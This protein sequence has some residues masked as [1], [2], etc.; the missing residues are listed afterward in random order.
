MYL[1]CLLIR[2]NAEFVK[3]SKCDTHENIYELNYDVKISVFT[4]TL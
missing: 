4:L 2:L 3:L 1:F